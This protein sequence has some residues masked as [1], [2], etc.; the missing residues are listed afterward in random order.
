MALTVNAIEPAA[1][2]LTKTTAAIV[3][4]HAHV[5]ALDPDAYPWRPTFGYIPTSPARPETLL[6]VMDRLGIAEA[7][8]VQP[9]A[10]GCDHRFL[11]DTIR[12]HSDRFHPVGL[13]DPADSKSAELAASLIESGCVGLRVNLSLNLG[14]ASAQAE[15]VSWAEITKTKVPICL[16]ATPAHHPLVKRILRRHESTRFVIDHLGLPDPGK[17]RETIERLSEL[18]RFDHCWLKLAGIARLS[19]TTPPYP[20]VWPL[21]HSVF[22]LFSPTRLVW[23]S[24]FPT[25]D[26]TT[27]YP[28]AVAVIERMPSMAPSTRDI[29]MAATSRNLWDLPER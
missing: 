25:A 11:F 23:G 4:S 13:V 27:G 20:D 14:Q 21:L 16:R 3:D 7:I 10:Y 29:V 26:P 28:A 22:E 15:A 19:T 8:L 2:K 5:W 1:T 9:S 18:A 24:D 17:P 12:A 6:T